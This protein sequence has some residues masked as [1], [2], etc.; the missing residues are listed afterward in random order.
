[1]NILIVEDEDHIAQGLRFNLEAEDYAVT[2]TDN[3]RDAVALLT[4]AE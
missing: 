2:L 1:M 4:A 3:G